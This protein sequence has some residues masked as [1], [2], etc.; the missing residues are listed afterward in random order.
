MK[1]QDFIAVL[2]IFAAIFIVFSDLF[3]L[4][5]AFLSGDHYEQQY[6]WATF[7]QSEIKQGHL[8]WWTTHIHSGFPLLA[9]GQIGAFYPIN[10][11]FFR[12][13]PVKIAYNYGI[14]FHYF[15][16]GLF[17]FFYLRR[18]KQSFW[19]S[20]FSTLIFLFGSTQGG[21]FYYNYISQKVVIWLP[22]T[23]L[24]CDRLLE[25]KSFRDAFLLSLVF[26]CEIF[27]GYLQVAAYTLLYAGLYFLLHWWKDR[28]LK[29]LGWFVFSG[30]L[31]I[32]FSL[33]QLL[34]TYE[35]AL[36]STR[37]QAFKEMAYIGS[38]N[39]LALMTMFY[40]NWDSVLGSEIYI[41]ILG[42]FFLLFTFARSKEKHPRIFWILS[43]FFL[44]LA[45]GSWS[46]LYR[47]IIEATKFYS[48]R[49]PIKFLFYVT[50]SLSILAGFGFDHF[51]GQA[52]QSQTRQP[53]RLFTWMLLG[54]ILLPPAI[55]GGLTVLKPR[56]LPIL[57][58]FAVK[59]FEGKPGHPHDAA[60]YRE[61]AESFYDTTIDLV[62]L[63]KYRYTRTSWLTLILSLIAV[64][65]VIN[66]YPQ[67]R[68]VKICACL[69]LLTDL[70]FYGFASIKPNYE[71]FQK[72]DT[73][74][75][76][77]LILK[78]L[79]SDKSLFRITELATVEALE[80]R[81]TV[82]PSANMIYGL[83]DLGAYSPL[84]M[85]SYKEFLHGWGGYMNDSYAAIPVQKEK[86]LARLDDLKRLNVKYI[87]SHTPLEH[88]EL[89]EREQEGK[90]WLYEMKAPW[91][92]AFYRSRGTLIPVTIRKYDQQFVAIEVNADQP[93]HVCLSDIAYPGWKAK[94][95]GKETPIEKWDDLFRMV[96]VF[97][98]FHK[99]EFYY[100]V[101]RYQRFG[102]AAAV[103]AGIGLILCFIP[104]KKEA[105][106][107]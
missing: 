76:E 98:G 11:I 67:K 45:L 102:I 89:I 62:N 97:A 40:P 15:L 91:P 41:G 25:K 80:N 103:I 55:Y 92:R 29:S 71:S 14:L 104:K 66:R 85:K 93:G 61:K 21:Y 99:I 72:F 28:N 3:T 84:V 90:E 96:P 16:G 50:F 23:L 37:A 19:A 73:L 13:L 69:I 9:E 101:S 5:Q 81:F 74:D 88:R 78:Y 56:L 48:F 12:F 65:T 47:G 46:P 8:P 17:F 105:Y 38:M 35:L 43:I 31:G 79:K 68:F 75:K 20:Y 82:S 24:L 54:M 33:V 60:G 51:F 27:G 42:V 58:E 107:A 63:L 100:D 57:Q 22:L 106:A 32:F 87:L 26:A 77:S 4:D 52:G 53:V 49:T 18:L 95:D 2:L 86:M 34:P 70:Y 64:L 36:F 59:Q 44:L 83:D 10:F 39:P 7:Y 1:R 6:P 30:F 94:I